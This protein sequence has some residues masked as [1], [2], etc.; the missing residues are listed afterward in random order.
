MH[1]VAFHA[2]SAA[3]DVLSLPEGDAVRA[4]RWTQL[5]DHVVIHTRDGRRYLTPRGSLMKDPRKV[6]TEWLDYAR[7]RRA[8]TPVEWHGRWCV[9][10]DAGGVW[11][12]YDA[13]RDG[14]EALHRCVLHPTEGRWHTSF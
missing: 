14:E 12:P 13:P 1:P 8:L 3:S 11:W 9:A 2:L 4:Q 10:H 5:V 7:A 6:A